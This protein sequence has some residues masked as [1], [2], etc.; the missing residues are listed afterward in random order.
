MPE[1]APQKR[2]P[3]KTHVPTTQRLRQQAPQRRTCQTAQK[4]S[5]HAR[6][7][8]SCLYKA[9]GDLPGLPACT[10]VVPR[11]VIS[12][13]SYG[14][15]NTVCVY[16]AGKALVTSISMPIKPTGGEMPFSENKKQHGR[17]TVCP[18]W[19]WPIRHMRLR[20][21]CITAAL[22]LESTCKTA[23]TAAPR[24]WRQRPATSRAGGHDRRLFRS[25][26]A[27]GPFCS[28]RTCHS[29]QRPSLPGRDK[30]HESHACQH[31]GHSN[32]NSKTASGP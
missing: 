22:L 3:E 32:A 18:A 29:R 21:V 14:A 16:P 9:R 7:A 5:P 28:G 4:G 30:G 2:I 20:F 8:Q 12:S 26:R 10:C 23:T 13:G 15:A 17:R 11:K 24:L 31:E 25:P 6:A 19:P 1:N 27:K